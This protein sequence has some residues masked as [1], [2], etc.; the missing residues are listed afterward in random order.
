[1][2]PIWSQ[3]SC[4]SSR[5][6]ISGGAHRG[7][8][9]GTMKRAGLLLAMS[10]IVMSCATMR[11]PGQELVARAVQAM[12]GAEVLAGVKT[13]SAKGTVRQWEP[14]QS[15]VPGGEMRFACESTFELASDAGTN[16]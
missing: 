11:P 1:M 8:Q 9:E 6:V 12:G 16:A 10:L 14:E 7:E 13:I 15:M 3:G 4:T 5:G 2:E